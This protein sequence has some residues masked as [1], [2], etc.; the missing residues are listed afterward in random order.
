[1]IVCD[2]GRMLALASV[3]V[4]FFLGSL[5]M[6]QLY[7]VALITGV[8]TVFFDVS[9][10][11]YLPA[12]IARSDLVEGNSK[13]QV[14][15]SVAQM[16]GPAIAGLLIQVLGAARAVIADA[17][18]FLVS[19]LS[20]WW[21]RKPEPAPHPASD[22]GRSEPTVHLG[23]LTPH[24]RADE[25]VG[26]RRRVVSA[27]PENLRDE[28]RI[29]DGRDRR[30]GRALPELRR[31]AAHELEREPRLADPSRPGECD[32]AGIGI[33]NELGE[34]SELALAPEQRSCRNRETP[35]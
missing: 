33:A 9:Y 29:A 19:V 3:P 20:L 22:A 24:H 4:A 11:S 13:L 7:V 26:R 16:A 1:M 10:Q 35:R 21:I 32:E 31:E 27:D 6:L 34:G 2:L 30:D 8:G 14:T 25:A 17:L 23:F 12:L 5:T 15:G 18:S 28:C